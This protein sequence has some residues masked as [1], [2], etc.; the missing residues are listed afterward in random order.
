MELCGFLPGKGLVIR[1]DQAFYVRERTPLYTR[2]MRRWKEP[3]NNA[4]ANR[5]FER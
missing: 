1:V 2:A 4:S 3:T 5:Q